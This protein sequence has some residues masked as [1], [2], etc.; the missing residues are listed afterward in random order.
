MQLADLLVMERTTLYRALNPLRRKGWVSLGADAGRAKTAT[1]T[2]RGQRAVAGATSAWEATQSRLLGKVG[3][4][5]W[6]RIESSLAKL[7][8][9]AV[10]DSA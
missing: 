9:V 2:P 1:L 6:A 10:G 7:V 8:A 5:E 3:R 4:R